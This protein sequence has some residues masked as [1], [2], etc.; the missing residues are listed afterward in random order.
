MLKA[1]EKRRHNE[2]A[3][4]ASFHGVKIPFKDAPER[5]LPTEISE[6][7]ARLQQQAQAEAQMRIADRFRR[8]H[9]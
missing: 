8:R 1:I 6:K 4:Q 3:V 7:E 5:E 9:G 2:T